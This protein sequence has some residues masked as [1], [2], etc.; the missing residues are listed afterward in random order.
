MRTISTLLFSFTFILTLFTV[1]TT[2]I[3]QEAPQPTSV[4]F[5]GREDCSFC[6]K[7]K[8]F[9]DEL[10]QERSD[11][12]VE[13]HDVVADPEAHELFSQLTESKKIAKV[14][15]ITV[16][17]STVIQG[18]DS[19]DTTGVYI[20]TLIDAFSGLETMEIEEVIA[21]RDTKVEH[22]GEGC[23]EGGDSVTCEIDFSLFPEQPSEISVPFFGTIDTEKFSLATL[24]I[25]LGFIDGFNPCAMWV[26]VT[27]LLVLAQIGNIKRM[28]IIAGLFILAEGIMYNLILNVWYHTWDFVKL[29]TIVAP[30]VGLLSVGGGAYFLYKWHKNKGKGLVCD[31]T[32]LE[33]QSKVEQKIHKI[34][35]TPLT[36]V[37]ILGVLGLAFSV[38]IIEFACSIGIPQ[39]FTK[40]LELNQLTFFE[41]Q[42]YILLYTLFYMVDDLIVF[43]LAIWGFGKIHAMGAKYSNMSSL[44]GGILMLIL[45]ILLL[46]APEILVFG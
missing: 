45:G 23:D 42:G 8:S 29:D 6:Q 38:N 25:I 22:S 7:Q 16:I 30:L 35:N 4:H 15:P 9:L 46:V 5:F 31:V 40:I 3:A 34:A 27:F 1:P 36:F 10:K 37:G 26:L 18:F 11:F 24:S 12:I 19:P 41:H 2:T 43:G 14:T 13:Y 28:V 20:T 32:S 33:H 44:I 21:A 17:G 39:A